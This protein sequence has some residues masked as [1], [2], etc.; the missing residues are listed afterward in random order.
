MRNNHEY[1]V[2]KHQVNETT[3]GKNMEESGQQD[4]RLFNPRKKTPIPTA[5]TDGHSLPIRMIYQAVHILTIVF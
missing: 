1:L 2:G 4:A 5:E 3:R